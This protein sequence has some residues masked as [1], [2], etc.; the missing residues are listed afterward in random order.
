MLYPNIYDINQVVEN[1]EI[2]KSCL[3]CG[4]EFT[5][6]TNGD[7]WCIDL[8][9]SKGKMHEIFEKYDNCICEECLAVYEME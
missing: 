9:I 7:C 4:K 8:Y 3:S 6:I 2:I 5:C 1:E